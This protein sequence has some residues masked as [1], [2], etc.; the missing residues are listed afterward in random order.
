MR[1]NEEWSAHNGRAFHHCDGEHANITGNRYTI[2]G[3][4]DYICKECYG[5]KAPVPEFVQLAASVL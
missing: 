2:T 5:C 3:E 4:I 1:I